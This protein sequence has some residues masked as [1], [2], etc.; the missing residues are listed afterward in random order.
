MLG[1]Q[2]VLEME[3]GTNIVVDSAT[4]REGVIGEPARGSALTCRFML[5]KLDLEVLGAPGEHPPH[6]SGLLAP[7]ICEHRIREASIRRVARCHRTTLATGEG[8]V[9]AR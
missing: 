2:I 7:Q 9:E 8:R 3:L 6:R 1:D 4:G 5:D